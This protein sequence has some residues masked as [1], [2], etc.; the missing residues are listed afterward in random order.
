MDQKTILEIINIFKWPLLV[1][2]IVL[3]FLKP[4]KA[5]INR[6]TNIGYGDK[7]IQASNQIA[8]DEEAT[9][10]WSRV[11]RA[12][13]LFRPET[14]E[15]FENAVKKETSYEDL[16]TAQEKIERLKN[17]SV[18]LYVIK[19]FESIYSSIFGS[20][21]RILEKL[22]TLN[23]ETTESLK[24]FYDNAKERYP[25]FYED[26]TYEQYLNFLF[27]FNLIREDEGKVSLTILGIDFLKY[28][29]ETNK[30][31]YKGY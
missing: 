17:Y 9:R 16:P 14:I 27:S 5:L 11:E 28:L 8:A 18:I 1:F 19:H 25:D 7:S 30:N 2:I 3:L 21:I 23:P 24:V 31:L 26:Y 13:G 4:L 22:N 29:A 12:L 15:M 10:E 20:Q 6:I